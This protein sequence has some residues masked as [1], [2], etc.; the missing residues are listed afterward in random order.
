[1]PL[2]KVF[3]SGK[4]QARCESPGYGPLHLDLDLSFHDGFISGSGR[5]V[6]GEFVVGGSY[7]ERMCFVEFTTTYPGRYAVKFMGMGQEEGPISGAW[8]L[9]KDCSGD[10][11]LEP[12]PGLAAGLEITDRTEDFCLR[13]KA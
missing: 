6:N 7:G 8:A 5:D 11:I 13:V 3:P 2:S 9:S 1:M 4:W 12:A 10:F